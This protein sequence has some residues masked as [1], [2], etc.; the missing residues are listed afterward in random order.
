VGTIFIPFGYQTKHSRV[1]GPPAEA[2]WGQEVLV[3][4]HVKRNILGA[5]PLSEAKIGTYLRAKE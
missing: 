3:E 1:G 2:H 4:N 5:S